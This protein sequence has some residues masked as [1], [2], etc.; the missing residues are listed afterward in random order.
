MKKLPS[1][2]QL[3]QEWSEL[4]AERRKLCTKYKAIKQE[5]VEFMTAKANADIVLFGERKTAQ[6]EHNRDE[7]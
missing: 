4:E 6:K 7:L 5:A 1:I 2:N 3:R